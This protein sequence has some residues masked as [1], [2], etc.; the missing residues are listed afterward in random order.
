MIRPTLEQLGDKAVSRAESIIGPSFA[1]NPYVMQHPEY[2]GS[3]L[4]NLVNQRERKGSLKS[5]NVELVGQGPLPLLYRNMEQCVQAAA[6]RID[7]NKGHEALGIFVESRDPEMGTNLY[8]VPEDHVHLV[9]QSVDGSTLWSQ[10]DN[11]LGDILENGG[12][13]VLLPEHLSN[14]SN[15]QK[16]E[17]GRNIGHI[18]GNDSIRILENSHINHNQKLSLKLETHEIDKIVNRGLLG[19]MRL[20]KAERVLLPFSNIPFTN[21]DF[22]DSKDKNSIH[23]VWLYGNVQGQKDIPFRPHSA[24]S[25]SE[26]LGACNCDCPDQLDAALRQLV[27]EGAGVVM[28]LPQEARGHGVWAKVQTWPLNIGH[29]IDLLTAFNLA[30]LQEDIREF[31]MVKEVLDSLGIRSIRLMSNNGHVKGKGLLDAGVDITD[32]LSIHPVHT[33][34]QSEYLRIDLKAKENDRGDNF[35]NTHVVQ[36]DLL[37]R[38]H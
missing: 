27:H 18:T 11:A 8:I 33:E 23:H 25:S 21:L 4:I 9:V 14:S 28:Y 20:V 12:G 6:F 35:H 17:I 3:G 22:I 19:R 29:K 36:G 24:C 34:H 32:M 30:G 38:R 16:I 37:L 10:V 1:T 15:K 13:I 2:F 31:T 5:G 26:V 7:E